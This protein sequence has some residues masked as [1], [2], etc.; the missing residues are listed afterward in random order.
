MKEAAITRHH[1]EGRASRAGERQSPRRIMGCLY[2]VM[3]H[4]Y[5][6]QELKS[7]V[8]PVSVIAESAAPGKKTSSDGGTT[9]SGEEPA[10]AAETLQEEFHLRYEDVE[11]KHGCFANI[12]WPPRRRGRGCLCTSSA[13]S[14]SDSQLD[15]RFGEAG[16]KADGLLTLTAKPKFSASENQNSES[17]EM[18]MYLCCLY[19]FIFWLL[20]FRNGFPKTSDEKI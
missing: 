7:S 11:D 13:S 10:G 18:R 6:E 14:C 1:E 5:T 16:V 2:R 17:F 3:L 20:I 15:A 8:L 9:S 12:R 4:R 19:L